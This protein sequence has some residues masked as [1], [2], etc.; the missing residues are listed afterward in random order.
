[1]SGILGIWYLDGRPVDRLELAR[2]SATLRHRGSDDHGMRVDGAA[3][4]ACRLARITRESAA[5]VQPVSDATGAMLVFDGRLDNREELLIALENEPAVSPDSPDSVL[6]LAAYR[7]F[8]DDAPA[9]LNGDFA[10]GLFDPRR[11]QLLLARD[12]IGV[13]PLYYFANRELFLFASEI[14]TLLSHPRV[15]TKPNDDALADFLFTRFAG[16]EAQEATFFQNVV[17]VPPA[18]AVIVRGP[19]A[20][21]THKYWDFDRSREVR[22][23]HYDDYAGAFKQ[24]FEQAV[25]RRLRSVAPVAIS[26]SGGLDSSAVFCVAETLRR[27]EP[28]RHPALLGVSQIFPDGSPSDEKGFLVEIERAY[29]VQIERH[30]SLG[31]GIVDDCEQAIWHGEAPFLDPQWNRTHGW[32]TAIR[33]SGARVILSGHWGDQMLFDDAYLVDLCRRGDWREAWR[34][35]NEYGRWVDVSESQFKRRLR[36]ALLKYYAPPVFVSAL[37]NLRNRLRPTAELRPWYTEGFRRRISSNG[38]S[39]IRPRLSA[40]AHAQSL[41]RQARSR[42]HGLCMEWNDKSAAMHGLETAFPF[43][44][45][46]LVA[47]LMAIPGEVQSWNGIYK[48]VFREGLRG[49]LPPAIAR[50]TEKADFTSLVNHEL[51]KDHD[52]VMERLSA[53][54]MTTAL[55]YVDARKLKDMA[56]GNV[57]AS[58]SQASRALIDLFSLELWLQEFF[59]SKDSHPATEA[60]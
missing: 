54:S 3:G 41:Y 19:A 35:V 27:S 47:F 55:G 60:F 14:K 59:G 32:L 57:R 51:V 33:Q 31:S 5:E 56:P 10:L 8:G 15:E 39:R 1:M 30:E 49:V 29:D 21:R 18:H 48:G 45:R 13:R 25:R 46:D 6:A 17:S 22:F 38:T 9:R 37:R 2:L 34:H 52:R 26:V 11:K 23:A 43:L 20:T 58:T 24:H 44:D 12:A 16:D 7:A 28:G 40:S 42:Y 50:R 4:L 53:P 36:T